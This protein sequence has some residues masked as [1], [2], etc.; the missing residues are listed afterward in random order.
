MQGSELYSQSFYREVRK[1]WDIAHQILKKNKAKGL[2]FFLKFGDVGSGLRTRRARPCDEVSKNLKFI[3]DFSNEEQRKEFAKQILSPSQKKLFLPTLPP[4]H[5]PQNMIKLHRSLSYVL[6]YCWFIY[7]RRGIMKLKIGNKVYLQKYEVAYIMYNLT[8][9]P[10]SFLDETFSDDDHKFFFM[11]SAA[12]GLRFDYA[13]E[14]PQNVAWLMEQDWIV[15]YAEY[16]KTS[17]DDIKSLVS[18][19]RMHRESAIDEFNS[20]SEDY[21]RTH[22]DEESAKFDRSAHK[23]SSLEKIIEYRQG[24]VEFVFPNVYREKSAAEPSKNPATP[25]K[26]NFFTRLFSRSAR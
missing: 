18:N 13:Y 21:R 15:D 25:K 19:L 8:E 3:L 4:L 20:K 17:F 5:F 23:I 12:D 1:G 24:E 9:L 10:G 2:Y 26:P 16:A 7:W 6:F 22:Y 14:D 11:N